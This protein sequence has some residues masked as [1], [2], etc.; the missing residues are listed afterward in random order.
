MYILFVVIASIF[1]EIV[2]KCVWK[3]GSTYITKNGARANM[4]LGQRNFLIQ[5]NWI[6][7]D[8]QCCVNGYSKR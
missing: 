6:I 5:Q 7:D 2:D 4:K 3:F 8:T 1:L